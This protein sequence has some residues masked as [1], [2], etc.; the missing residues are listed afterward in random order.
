MGVLAGERTHGLLAVTDPLPPATLTA[1]TGGA[2]SLGGADPGGWDPAAFARGVEQ[3]RAV[4]PDPDALG[5]LGRDLGPA[6]A[7]WMLECGASSADLTMPV[8]AFARAPR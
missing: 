5:A 3:A 4:A 7:L 1:M 6:A 8:G 2:R